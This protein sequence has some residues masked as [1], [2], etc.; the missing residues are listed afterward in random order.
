MF[1]SY[2]FAQTLWLN[3]NISDPENI[4]IKNLKNL[5]K[6][7]IQTSVLEILNVGSAAIIR[8][9]TYIHGICSF[10]GREYAMLISALWYKKVHNFAIISV[11]IDY[12]FYSVT[13][14]IEFATFLVTI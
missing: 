12:H 6:N 2:F 1:Q 5:F 10:Y 11:T 8:R 4:R 3:K 7:Q 13:I 14:F 9:Y